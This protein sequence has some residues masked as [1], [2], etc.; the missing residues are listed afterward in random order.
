L[1][2]TRIGSILC[3]SA[4]RLAMGAKTLHFPFDSDAGRH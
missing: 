4:P 1:S 2:Y 3:Q